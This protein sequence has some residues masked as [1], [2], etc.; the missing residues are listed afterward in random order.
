MTPLKVTG[1]PLAAI[2]R[3]PTSVILRPR[4][5]VVPAP[6][7]TSPPSVMALP[8]SVYAGAPE[9]K[10]I[11]LIDNPPIS[12]VRLAKAEAAKVSDEFADGTTPPDQLSPKFQSVEVGVALH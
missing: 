3:E 8:V 11:R 12:L 10:V 9:L 7:R 4:V 6:L 1:P 5:W 2:V